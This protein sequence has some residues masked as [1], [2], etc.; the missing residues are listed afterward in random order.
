MPLSTKIRSSFN[1]NTNTF[2]LTLLRKLNCLFMIRRNMS[3]ESIMEIS[4]EVISI[5]LIQWHKSS[6]HYD[7]LH[8]VNIVPYLFQ[9][10]NSVSSLNVWIVSSSYSS[11]G[12]R[13]ISSIWLS[14]IFEVR[15][16]SSRTINTN[17]SSCCYMRASMRFAHNCYNCNTTCCPDWLCFKKRSQFGFIVFRNSINYFHKFWRFRNFIL[18][19][20][21]TD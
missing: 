1:G 9:L 19:C 11:H 13:F 12:S 15:V 16:W 10:L 18:P 14:W 4:N 3:T 21:F 5:I 17:I 7:K 2:C 20:S 8:F 6:T